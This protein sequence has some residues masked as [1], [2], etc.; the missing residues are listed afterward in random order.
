MSQETIQIRRYPNR[1]L[2]DRESRRYVTLAE[3]EALVKSGRMVEVRDSKTGED[4][5]RTI[6]TQI[7]LERHPERMAM[8]PVGLLHAMLQANDKF[9]N[10]F[11]DSM[12]RSL[13]YFTNLQGRS[14]MGGMP[15]LPKG[16]PFPPS[17]DWLQTF[18][19]GYAPAK[20]S[21]GDS[22]EEP[23]LEDSEENKGIPGEPPADER[24]AV[25]EGALDDRLASHLTALE[26]RLAQLEQAARARGGN[27]PSQAE[28]IERLEKRIRELEQTTDG[29]TQYDL[30][31]D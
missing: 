27:P 21:P 2:Y 7:I 25:V 31:S 12:R 22:D 10:F 17:M 3:I 16:M 30:S 11:E 14:P 15:G 18:M 6:L 20:P 9:V 8:F 23:P 4:I 1:R 26:A 19:G 29:G 13:E 24:E 5:T 28:L